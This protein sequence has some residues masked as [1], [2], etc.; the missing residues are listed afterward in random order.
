[1]SRRPEQAEAPLVA[2]FLRTEKKLRGGMR[3]WSSNTGFGLLGI[4]SFDL[5]VCVTGLKER[6]EPKMGENAA[7]PDK[8]RK[9]GRLEDGAVA[10]VFLANT[11][12]S[13]GNAVKV[14]FSM[15]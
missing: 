9:C 8:A 15:M 2:G 14:D 13:G 7:T 6:L 4:G 12:G 1:M 5:Y 3:A 10:A 11:C